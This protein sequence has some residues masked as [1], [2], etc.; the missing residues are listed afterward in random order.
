MS[1][2][3]GIQTKKERVAE[4]GFEGM[5]NRGVSD[6]EIAATIEIAASEVEDV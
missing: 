6:D 2:L 4:K 1:R 5:R 3:L